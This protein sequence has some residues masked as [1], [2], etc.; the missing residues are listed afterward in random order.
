M[1]LSARLFLPFRVYEAAHSGAFESTTPETLHY[2]QED[3]LGKGKFEPTTL[4]H[5][6]DELF[7][8][9]Q[10]CGV[11]EAD[12]KQREEWLMDTLEY[13]AE[14]YP[15]LTPTELAEVRT[16][17]ERYCKPA[18][19]HGKTDAR[20]MPSFTEHVHADENGEEAGEAKPIPSAAEDRTD[21]NPE[22]SVA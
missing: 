9:I 20:D 4:D 2:Q 1:P 5:A 3:F 6:R 13:I 14:R 7:S 8:H 18:I 19:P 16:M 22:V 12:P 11:L 17:G 10:R 15:D 21:Q